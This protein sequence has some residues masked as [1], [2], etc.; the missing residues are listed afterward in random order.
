MEEKEE[1]GILF[2]IGRFLCVR[3]AFEEKLKLDE[4]NKGLLPYCTRA[5]REL[6]PSSNP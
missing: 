2:K 4:L 5:L 3:V 6:L 1:V